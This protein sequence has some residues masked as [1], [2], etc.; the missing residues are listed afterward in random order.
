[1]R[2]LISAAAALAASLVLSGCAAMGAAD[3]VG[4]WVEA[5]HVDMTQAACQTVFET[6]DKGKLRVKQAYRDSI[7]TDPTAIDSMLDCTL[8]PAADDEMKLLRG[9]V[10]VGLASRYAL[11]KLT[12][13]YGPSVAFNF[14]TYDGI[15]KDAAAII[16]HIA[17]SEHGLR[18]ASPLFRPVST[19]SPPSPT[20]S[21]DRLIYRVTPILVLVIKA[22]MPTYNRARITVGHLVTGLAA[23]N[24]AVLLD[25]LGPVLNGLESLLVVHAMGPVYLKDVQAFLK[26]VDQCRTGGACQS[27]QTPSTAVQTGWAQWD[28]KLKATCKG[29]A[30]VAMGTPHCIPSADELNEEL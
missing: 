15:D 24:T 28:T 13:D 20:P 29:I 22:D 16:Q 10:L 5:G 23:G 30:K 18:R 12:G 27:W 2:S 9:H 19:T 21:V 4:Q 26:Q 8:Y 17:I 6:N 1:M 25:G 3:T 11:F 14:S 7:L